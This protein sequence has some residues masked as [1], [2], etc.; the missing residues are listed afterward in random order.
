[1]GFKFRGRTQEAEKNMNNVRLKKREDKQMRFETVRRKLIGIRQ[2]LLSESKAEIDQILNQE[3]KYNGASDDG[4]LADISLRDLMQAATLTRHQAQL[5]AVEEALLRIEEGVY[6]ICED[7]GEEIPIGRL[8]A[9]PFALRCV[10][11]QERHETMPAESREV[12]LTSW[13][14]PGGENGD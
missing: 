2:N 6:G 9:M 5:R 14:S 10:D 3:D 4:D 7:C 8:N 12:F 13:G 11:C 1:M